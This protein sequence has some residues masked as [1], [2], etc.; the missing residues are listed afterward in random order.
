M[1]DFEKGKVRFIRGGKYPQSN[2]VLIDDNIRAIIDPACNEE[3]LLSIHRERHIEVVINSHGHE[4]HFLYNYLFPDAQLWVHRMDAEVFKDMGVFL[5][6][7]Y[8]P[9]EMSEEVTA[10]WTPFLTEVVKYQPKEPDRLLEDKEIIAFGQ[11]R[12]QVLHTPGHTP[13]HL[14]FYFLNEKVLYLADL[15]LVKF[16]PYYGDNSS[17]IDDIIKSLKRLANIDAD[18]YLVSHGKEGILDGD[19]AYFQNYI[20]VIYQREEKLVTFLASGPKTLQEITA[21]GIING[22][23]KLP[24]GPW[25]LSMSEKSMMRKHLGRLV[26]T[27]TVKKEN[28]TYELSGQ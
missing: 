17:S 21:Y 16:G 22:G 25:D 24:S 26:R 23:R 8:T 13:G 2:S 9:D 19:P 27:G 1:F 7:L 3:K 10:A 20:D 14:S 18:V 12:V 4:D 11:T 15:D 6:Q 28:G 5:Q